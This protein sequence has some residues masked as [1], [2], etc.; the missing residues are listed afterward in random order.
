MTHRDRYFFFLGGHDL[1][2][3]TLA[4]L[5]AREAPGRFADKRL[6]W[7][8]KA[9]DYR[10][11]IEAALARG[12]VPVL[13]ELEPDLE[14]PREV[15]VVVDHHGD[16]AGRER[17]TSLEQV[18]ELLDLPPERWSRWYEL[19]AAND[20]GYIPALRRAGASEEEIRRVR[21]ADR[22]AQG[23][24]E[25]DE[26]ATE[27]A[28]AS[29]ERRCDGRLLV[30]RL[31]HGRTTALVDRLQPELGGPG[32]ENLL[33]FSPG[34]VNFFGSGEVVRALAEAYPQGWWGGDLPEQGFWGHPGRPAGVVEVVCGRVGG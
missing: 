34:E 29:L 30:A 16:R 9:S 32:F 28:L 24:T 17:P 13:V 2:M 5:L 22:A 31:S 21:A 11:E 14:L 3:V 33:V 26:Q 25:E 4:E 18:F 27:A 20:R 10:R 7:G 1:E 12:D 15:V 19:V 23:I 8:A 6:S